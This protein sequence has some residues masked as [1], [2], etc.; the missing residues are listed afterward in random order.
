MTVQSCGFVFV[1]I[2]FFLNFKSTMKQFWFVGNNTKNSEND[3]WSV[4]RDFVTFFLRK[5]IYHGWQLPINYNN[6]L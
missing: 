1:K 5:K 6:S 2:C 4:A 3:K